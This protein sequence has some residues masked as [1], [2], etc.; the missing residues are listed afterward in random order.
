MFTHR[1]TTRVIYG[2]TDN[3]GVA[4]HG[5]YMRW[6]EIGRAEMFRSLGLSYRVIESRGI[7]LPVSEVYC[8]YMTPARYDDLLVIDT[9][10]DGSVK[11][12]VKFNYVLTSEN[13]ETVY[14][15]GYTRHACVNADGRV[16][17]PPAF[18][19]KIIDDISLGNIPDLGASN[20]NTEKNA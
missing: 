1:A 3:M 12:G 11:G 9:S 17:R 6:F 7:F 19:K 8:K 13:G 15:K 5:N 10:I 16:V 2:D 18:L 20:E 4:Y 14:A